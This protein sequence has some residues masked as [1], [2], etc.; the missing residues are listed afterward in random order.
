MRTKWIL[1]FFAMVGLLAW[2]M[3]ESNSLYQGQHTFS[4]TVDCIKCHKEESNY[5]THTLT[6]NHTMDCKGCHP[7]DG[8]ESHSAERGTCYACH[9]TVPISNAPTLPME[10]GAPMVD[11]VNSTP[12]PIPTS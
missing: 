5:L 2:T 10:D 4:P 12:I 3:P 9:S 11:V 7:R 6:P 8:L 1:I